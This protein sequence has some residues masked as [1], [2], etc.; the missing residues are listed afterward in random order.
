[1][2]YVISFLHLFRFS[3]ISIYLKSPPHNMSLATEKSTVK[4]HRVIEHVYH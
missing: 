4:H 1:M 3:D 2:K